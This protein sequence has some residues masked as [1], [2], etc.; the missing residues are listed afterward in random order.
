M[1]FIIIEVAVIA[2]HFLAAFATGIF[3]LYFITAHG[4]IGSIADPVMLIVEWHYLS[5]PHPVPLK[6]IDGALKTRAI[7][8]EQQRGEV[9]P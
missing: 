8:Y 5:P 7:G 3:E 4:E 6:T 9:S 1:S 2:A